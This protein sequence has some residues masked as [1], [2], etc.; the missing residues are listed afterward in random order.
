G[1]A[2]PLRT[3]HLEGLPREGLRFLSRR[4]TDG[5]ADRRAA[6]RC[7]HGC[8]LRPAWAAARGSPRPPNGRVIPR[9]KFAVPTRAAA[10]IIDRESAWERLQHPDVRAGEFCGTRS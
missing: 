6:E 5:G 10:R 1:G 2:A 9:G 8:G 3:D 4:H 7:E